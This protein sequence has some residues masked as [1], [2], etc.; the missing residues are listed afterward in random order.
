MFFLPDMKHWVGLGCWNKAIFPHVGHGKMRGMPS[1]GVF[2]KAHTYMH[3]QTTQIN[4]QKPLFCSQRTSKYINLGENS[5]SKILN[6]I[7]LLPNGS[8]VMEVKVAFYNVLL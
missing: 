6:T 2:V 8:R 4:L 1:V 7:L 3:T 5:M